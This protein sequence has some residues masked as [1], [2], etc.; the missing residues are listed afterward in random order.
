MKQSENISGLPYKEINRLL[1]LKLQ[2]G[3]VHLSGRVILHIRQKHDDHKFCIPKIVEVV[4]S[5]K[6]VGMSPLHDK[7]F[8]IVKSFKNKFV[9]VAIS[10][11]QDIHGDY[12]IMSSYLI[13][14]D[15]L[16][17]RLRKGHLKEI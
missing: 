15:V 6:Y 17:R 13:D 1:K 3:T 9:L 5:P 7:N 2:H 16:K 12:P 11:E 4:E 14:E 10:S 8:M